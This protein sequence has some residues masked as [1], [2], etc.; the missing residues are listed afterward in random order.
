MRDEKSKMKLE[1]LRTDA[2]TNWT[3]KIT[4]ERSKVVF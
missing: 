1:D 2:Q 3:L 4:D